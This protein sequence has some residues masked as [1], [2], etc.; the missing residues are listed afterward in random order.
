MVALLINSNWLQSCFFFSGN[1]HIFVNQS[2]CC[3][4]MCKLFLQT[5]RDWL[6]PLFLCRPECGRDLYLWVF[7]YVGHHVLLKSQSF[8]DWI[9]TFYLPLP[10]TSNFL[11]T[12][13]TPGKLC[14]KNRVLSSPNSQQH[15][16]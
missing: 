3:I 13:F 6:R 8:T 15:R 7:R 4:S 10:S 12:I 2:L 9:L 16:W 11:W 1:G 14:K 5:M